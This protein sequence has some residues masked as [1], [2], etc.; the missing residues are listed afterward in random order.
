MP[1]EPC[2]VLIVEDDEELGQAIARAVRALDPA[3]TVLGTVA[4]A[5]RFLPQTPRL[6]ILDV[7]LPDGNGLEIAEAAAKLRPVPSII[8]ISGSATAEEAFAL[9]Q[10]GVRGY[11]QK[12]LSLPDLRD[13]IGRVMASPPQ[14]G[15]IV[16][17]LVGQRPIQDVQSE[18]RRVMV[19]QAVALTK[20]NRTNASHLLSVSRQ[21]VQQMARDMDLMPPASRNEPKE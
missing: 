10:R 15:P 6:I 7:G 16:A 18:I 8:A 21:A 11:L 20:G 13:T 12:P 17:S 14:L 19:E 1:G 4:A 5:L 2:R 9:A 3:A